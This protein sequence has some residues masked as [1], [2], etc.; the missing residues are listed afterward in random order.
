MKS[1]KRNPIKNL[2]NILLYSDSEMVEMGCGIFIIY[3]SLT[4]FIDISYILRGFFLGIGISQILSLLYQSLRGR[5][6]SNIGTTLFYS[7][8]FI[9]GIK[10]GEN[11]LNTFDI[12]ILVF[13]SVW[14]WFRTTKELSI[15]YKS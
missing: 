9:S 2:L 10:S 8:I 6:I 15:K 7:Y 14:A 13:L 12:L 11:L 3:L 1:S 4:P 5:N